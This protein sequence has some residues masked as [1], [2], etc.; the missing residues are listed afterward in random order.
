MKQNINRELVEKYYK[1]S[2]VDDLHR[3]FDIDHW[4]L[5]TEKDKVYVSK[6]T[7]FENLCRQT[8]RAYADIVTPVCYSWKSAER[9]FIFSGIFAYLY[10][11]Q[12]S[13]SKYSDE[14]SV[15]GF[16]EK[17]SFPEA[18][19]FCPKTYFDVVAALKEATLAPTKTESE[20]YLAMLDVVVPYFQE[21]TKPYIE[22]I[23]KNGEIT[24]SIDAHIADL[25][26]WVANTKD[27]LLSFY[28]IILRK[29]CFE[30]GLY[31]TKYFL[32]DSLVDQLQKHDLYSFQDLQERPIPDDSPLKNCES[33]EGAMVA[34]YKD[35]DFLI[36]CENQEEDEMW[37]LEDESPEEKHQHDLYNVIV[38]TLWEDEKFCENGKYGV[39]DCRGRIIV[40]PEYEDCLGELSLVDQNSQYEMIIA[41]KQDGKWGFVKRNPYLEQVVQFQYDLVENT[42]YGVYLTQIGDHYG[43]VGKLGTE[44]LP[45]IMEEIYKPSMFEGDIIYKQDGKYGFRMHN[46]CRSTELF[47]EVDL[48]KGEYIAVCRNGEWGYIDE[49]A[50]FTA[51]TENALE[52]IGFSFEKIDGRLVVDNFLSEEELDELVQKHL[53]I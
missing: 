16:D 46:G 24:R 20:D 41:L 30:L 11:A 42:M 35:I 51:S 50:Q 5:D 52:N 48:E 25:C 31:D 10:I 43:I 49:N 28:G 7:R 15:L 18:K 2:F 39:K 21:L 1:E 45:T 6:G 27:E 34:H 44:I 13:I 47:D 17:F 53:K 12:K 3:Y 19:D 37:W 22:T 8:S 36:D 9:D 32:L 40:P 33:L 4:Y 38:N 23:D 29:E 26:K 14:V